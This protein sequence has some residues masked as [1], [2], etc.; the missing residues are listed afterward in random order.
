[1]EAIKQVVMLNFLSF[2]NLCIKKGKKEKKK[3]RSSCSNS[4]EGLEI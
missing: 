2:R 4:N 3:K 1:M